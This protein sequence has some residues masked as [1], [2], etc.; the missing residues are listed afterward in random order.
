MSPPQQN[1]EL[2][3][4]S[5]AQTAVSPAESVLYMGDLLENMRKIAQ[6]HGLGVLAHLLELAR[7]ETRMVA[8]DLS[9]PQA[10]HG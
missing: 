7:V 8:R 9:G 6:A 5:L 2:S 4:P 3:A 10:T 1:P